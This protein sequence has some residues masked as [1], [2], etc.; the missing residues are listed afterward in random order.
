MKNNVALITGA[1]SGLGAVFARHLAAKGYDL[2]LV[3]RREERLAALAAELQQQYSISV[4]ILVADLARPADVER[5]EGRIAGIEDL[6]VLVNNAGF[7]TTGRF[8]EVDLA[9]SVA[10][11]EVHVVASMR[12]CR[13]ALPGMIA[14]RRGALINVSSVAAFAPLPGNANYAAS[15]AYVLTFSKALHAELRESGIKVQAL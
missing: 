11:V 5:V 7:G 13:A 3:A 9:K 10:M 6:D 14:R 15:K 12:F 4:E 2:V 8:A 1:S